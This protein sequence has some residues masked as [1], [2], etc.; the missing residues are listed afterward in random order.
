M[1]RKRD[2]K[3]LGREKLPRNE[4]EKERFR[5]RQENRLV[6]LEEEKKLKE[7]GILP[8]EEIDRQF[9]KT[10]GRW[11]AKPTCRDW[12]FNRDCKK[13]KNCQFPHECLGCP[14]AAIHN[15]YICPIAI[16]RK[17]IRDCVEGY[18]KV[19]SN[20]PSDPKLDPKQVEAMELKKK[21]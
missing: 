16:G 12:F 11:V 4:K 7:A 17:T 9:I 10:E 5:I 1:D 18:K 15:P 21:N 2:P 20:D 13:P 14:T 3:H 19:V 6:L 8:W